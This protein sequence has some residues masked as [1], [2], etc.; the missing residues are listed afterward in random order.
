MAYREVA[1]W[2]I[3]DVLRR[4]QGGD[5][6]F[7]NRADDGPQPQHGP[8]LSGSGRRAW[9]DAGCRE[10]TE[11]LAAEIGRRLSPA[12]GRTAGEAEQILLPHRDQIGRG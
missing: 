1:M 12:R 4:V 2:E 10:P 8:T 7:G 9:L 11:A 5:N 6:Q 3:L